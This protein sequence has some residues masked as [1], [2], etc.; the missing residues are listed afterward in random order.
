MEK[1]HIQEPALSKFLFSSTVAAWLLV[2]LGHHEAPRSDGRDPMGVGPNP[3]DRRQTQVVDSPVNTMHLHST[4]WNPS[5]L[6]HGPGRV[7]AAGLFHARRR[8]A[9]FTRSGFAARGPHA[10]LLCKLPR[11]DF[12]SPTVTSRFAPAP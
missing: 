7:T 1:I 2:V 11:V 6:G 12:T 9:G 10:L 8:S 4:H 3:N 5:P